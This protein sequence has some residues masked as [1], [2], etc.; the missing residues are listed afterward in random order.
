[1]DQMNI[2]INDIIGSLTSRIAQLEKEKAVLFAQLNYLQKPHGQERKE[3][4]SAE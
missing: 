1:M 3:P 2:D 4:N